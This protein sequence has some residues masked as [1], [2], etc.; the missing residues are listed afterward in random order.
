M[1]I[2]FVLFCFIFFFF[3]FW[4]YEHITKTIYHIQKVCKVEN[5]THPIFYRHLHGNKFRVVA[6]LFFIIFA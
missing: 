1:D 3:F 5:Y 6:F 4:K 2:H